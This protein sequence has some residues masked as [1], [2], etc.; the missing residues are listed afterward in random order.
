MDREQTGLLDSLAA[1]LARKGRRVWDLTVTDVT[2]LAP[3]LVR[4]IFTA[5]DL[6]ELMWKRG[7]DLVLELPQGDGSVARRH[8]TIRD[9][10]GDGIAIDFVRHGGGAAQAWLDTAAPGTRLLASGPRGHTH[11]READWHLFAGDETAMPGIFAMLEGLPDG[12]KAFAFLEAMDEDDVLFP[13]CGI[14]PQWVFRRAPP[15]PNGLLREALSRF[16]FPYGLGQAYLIGETSAVRAIRHDL[17]ARGWPK[18]RIVSEGYWR[19]G[20]VG[21]HDHV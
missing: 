12:A 2:A 19:P 4:L 13:A 16:A 1:T 11:L 15:A 17:I 6:H 7:Q 18:E 21:G 3:R 9:H 8:Y 5:P 10:K 20:R 14:D